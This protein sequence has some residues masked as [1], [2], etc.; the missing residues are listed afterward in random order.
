V[1]HPIAQTGYGGTG[2]VR[3]S[4]YR[5]AIA[6]WALMAGSFIL[7]CWGSWDTLHRMQTNDMTLGEAFMTLSFLWLF[8]GALF[9]VGID[10]AITSLSVDERHFII[11]ERRPTTMTE[12]R[13]PVTE[14]SRPRVAIDYDVENL[15]SYLIQVAEPGGIKITVARRWRPKA[16]QD[17][18]RQMNEIIDRQAGSRADHA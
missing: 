12:I 15:A 3:L 13:F 2:E 11:R 1:T 17:L 14:Q 8:A 18:L 5:D 7:A 4:V 6:L 9:A 16:A 10:E